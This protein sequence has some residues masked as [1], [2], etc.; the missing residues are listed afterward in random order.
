M[1]SSGV[2]SANIYFQQGI[3]EKD[4]EKMLLSFQKGMAKAD[5]K[6]DTIS[7]Y[8]LDGIIYSRKRQKNY[9]STLDYTDSLI[10][11]AKLQKN[12][13]FVALA[14]YRKA[15]VFQ[16]LNNSEEA[17][18]NYY[19]SRDL[20]L[21]IGDSLRAG[22]RSLEMA[23][24]QSRMSDYYGSQENATNA[25]KLLLKVKDSAYINSAYNVIAMSYRERGFYDDALKEYKNALRYSISKEDSLSFLN[26]I[27]LVYR[28]KGNYSS[29]L[30]IFQSVLEQKEVADEN[31]QARFID[32]YAYTRWMQDSNAL[33]LDELNTA[34]ALRLKT[35]DL[36]GLTASYEHLSSYFQKSKPDLALDYAFKWL[37][38]ARENSSKTSELNALKRI[39]NYSPEEGSKIFT[40]S[41]IKLNDSIKQANINAKNT[42]AKVKFD[43]EQKLQEILGL[44]KRNNQQHIEAQQQRDRIIIISLI[45]AVITLIAAFLLYYFKQRHKKDK[46]REVYNTE[47]RISKKIHDELANDIYNVMGRLEPLANTEVLDSLENIYTR[48]RDISR[49]NNEINTSNSYEEDLIANL[50]NSSS[51][52]TKLIVTGQEDILWANIS[53]EKK[54]VIYRV[55]QELLVNMKKHSTASLVAIRFIAKSKKVEIRYSDNGKGFDLQNKIP[56][57]GIKNV[58]NRIHSTNGSINFESEEGK[59]LKVNIQIPV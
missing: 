27:A 14:Y 32:N 2:D 30:S 45:A 12:T 22:Q 24:A 59:G 1:K 42:F 35:K 5:R 56:G 49:E 23:N 18:R 53:R 50:S 13:Y 17:Y 57:N 38:I 4:P 34:L 29:S 37:E 39:I 47:T 9:D 54:I 21:Q 41:F 58:E 51:K 36:N 28:D 16:A 19:K 46:I 52:N 25:L 7:L 11:T 3:K 20:F 44:E 40:N 15:S 26:N 55:L 48:T 6:E 8:L 43:E 10:Y 33:V 31:S